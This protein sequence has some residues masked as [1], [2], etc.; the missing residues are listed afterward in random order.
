MAS[1]CLL[2]GLEN[3]T[4]SS[5]SSRIK[6]SNKDIALNTVVEGAPLGGLFACSDLRFL[7]CSIQSE[8]ARFDFVMQNAPSQKA[9]SVAINR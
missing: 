3:I 9:G 1:S 4:A 6:L 8:D 5:G 7:R 2:W